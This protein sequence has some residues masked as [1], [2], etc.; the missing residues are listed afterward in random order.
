MQW[1]SAPKVIVFTDLDG[2]F[3]GH[4]QF[5]SKAS[6]ALL[7]QLIAYGVLVVFN[8]SKTWAECRNLLDGLGIRLPVIVENGSAL[9]M[10]NAMLRTSWL[11]CNESAN[12]LTEAGMSRWVLGRDLEAIVQFKRREAS[13]REDVLTCDTEF[14]ETLTGLSGP[15][16][17]RA[18][19]REYSLPL[20]PDAKDPHL[21]ALAQA[22]GFDLVQGGRLSSLQGQ[23]DKGKAMRWFMS[24]LTDPKGIPTMS[25]GD[26]ANDLPML[27][28]SDVSI[29]V[30]RQGKHIP[31]ACGK[32]I[33]KTQIEAPEGWCE[34]VLEGLHRLGADSM[35]KGMTQGA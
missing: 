16:L 19:Q 23:T 6:S 3:L 35:I 28:A 12:A 7:R 1:G 24:L 8:T 20:K 33:Y 21:R 26:S 34:G 30:K 4:D 31:Y 22:Q 10:P 14:A 5:D 11:T 15:E 29:I 27:A 13:D 25:L 18:Q 32:T 9:L 17:A 2:T